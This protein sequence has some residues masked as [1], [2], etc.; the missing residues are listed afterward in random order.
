MSSAPERAALVN[1]LP[2]IGVI[3]VEVLALHRRHELAVDEVVVRRL[4]VD[5]GAGVLGLA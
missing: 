2:V 3:D 5:L 4:E 1:A